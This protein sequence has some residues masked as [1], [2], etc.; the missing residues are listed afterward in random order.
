[1]PH[2]P[3]LAPSVC[4]S[5]HVPAQLVVPVGQPHAPAEQTRLLPQICE[6]R[7]QLSL[8]FWRSTHDAFGPVPH[9][10]NPDAVHR[11]AQVPSLQTGSVPVQR[12]PQAPQFR[13]S[14]DV[15]M[16]V[17]SPPKRPAHCV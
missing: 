6:Q 11:T 16:Q 2:V 4:R 12:V 15:S 17:P 7:P 1:V 8:L 10:V 3:Q 5:E 14:L 13:A 9:S